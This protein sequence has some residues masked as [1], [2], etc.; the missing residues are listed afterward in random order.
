MLVRSSYGVTPD[1]AAV[2]LYILGGDAGLR[3]QIITYGGTIIG[4]ETPDRDGIRANVV[5]SLPT[6]A[7][8]VMQDA[9]LGA[10][11]GRHANRIGGASFLLDGRKYHLSKNDGDNCLH[12]GRSASTKRSGVSLKARR[13][14]NRTSPFA[15]S[16]PT[17]TR[18]SPV[19][20]PLR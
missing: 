18:A 13:P 1:G 3:A 7:D 5:L 6:L 8:Y 20:S 14:R 4:I 10:L 15:I 11:V 9:Y 19:L 2:D 16:A 17:E 12:G